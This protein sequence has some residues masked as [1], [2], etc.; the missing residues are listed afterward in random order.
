MEVIP[1]PDTDMYLSKGTV[2]YYYIQSD[3]ASG[4]NVTISKSG[5]GDGVIMAYQKNSDSKWFL[6]NVSATGE[7]VFVSK[8]KD[9]T[10]LA[11]DGGAMTVD[12]QIKVTTKSDPKTSQ[13]WNNKDSKYL[14]M[15]GSVMEVKGGGMTAGTAVILGNKKS[16][17]NQQFSLIPVTSSRESCSP[18]GDKVADDMIVEKVE[19]E[20][21]EPQI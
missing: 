1:A 3:L 6:E 21:S 19:I 13:K 15:N 4:F 17:P 12:T 11:L 7:T 5:D 10:R 14:Q 8:R 20:C 2:T 18:V 9:G 16:K